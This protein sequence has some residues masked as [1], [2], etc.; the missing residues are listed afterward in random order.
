MKILDSD[1]CIAILRG[2]LSL[3]GRI[4]CSEQLFVTSITVGELTHGVFKSSNPEKNLVRINLL[5]AEMVVLPFDTTA[6]SK[7]G[8][9]KAELEKAGI[10]L[11]D[12]DLQIAAIALTLNA[13]LITHNQKHFQR[14][15]NLVLEDWL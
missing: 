10:R 8:H 7:F 13:S 11:A 12:L 15:P 3:E 14:I 1:H 4:D 9:L 5:L 2:N 6:G